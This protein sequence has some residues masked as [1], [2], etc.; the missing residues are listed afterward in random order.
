MELV[1]KTV[2][3]MNILALIICILTN[4]SNNINID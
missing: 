2:I 4:I 3:S 1:I